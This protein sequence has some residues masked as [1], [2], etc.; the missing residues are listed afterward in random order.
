M[1]D[2]VPGAHAPAAGVVASGGAS[3]GDPLAADDGDIE[4]VGGGE[5]VCGYRR[6][7]DAQPATSIAAATAQPVVTVR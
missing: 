7:D 3:P 5:P 6:P 2:P 4:G 1:V